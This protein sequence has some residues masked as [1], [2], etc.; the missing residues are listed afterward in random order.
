MASLREA[1]AAPLFISRVISSTS[2][3]IGQVAL[4]WGVMG[5]GYGARELSLVV[6]CSTFPALLILCGGVIGDRFRRHHVLMGAEL[7]ACLAWLALGAAFT[8]ERAPLPLLCSLAGLS[9]VAAAIFMPTV[10]GIIADLLE[11]GQRR[12]GNAL[13]SQTEALGHLIGFVSAGAVVTLAGPA[14]A[15]AV[16]GTLCGI[17]AVLL[18][19]LMTHRPGR[20][21]SGPIRELREGWREFTGRPWVWIMTLHYTV[22]TAALVCYMKIVGPLYT[23]NGHGGALAWG[24]IGAAQPLGALAGAVI[25]VRWRPA[26]LVPVTVLLPMSVSIPMLLMGGEAPWPAIA[27]AALVPGAAQAVYYVFWT[28]ALQD[29]IPHAALVRV[30]SWNLVTGYVLMPVTVLLS[31]PLVV[32]FG[33]QPIVVTAAVAA[34]AVTALTLLVLWVLS[35]ARSIA[36]AGEDPAPVPIRASEVTAG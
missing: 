16:R 32:G 9:G 5:M 11:G 13:V 14:S 10:R 20:T 21:R 12:A 36:G 19:R 27:A 17:S 18:S 35:R 15:A 25:G 30:N 22:I 3:G 26:H 7:L 33:L 24:V 23:E 34:I 1:S 4:A 8:M 2:V 6:A 29:E 31:G 28:T